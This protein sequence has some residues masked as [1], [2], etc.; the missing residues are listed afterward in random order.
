MQPKHIAIIMDGNHRWAK[1][2]ILPVKLG[3]KAGAS[4]IKELIKSALEFKIPYITIYAFSTENWSRP[5][6]EVEDLMKLLQ[7]YLEND[8]KDLIKYGVKI[9]SS[10]ELSKL[11]P[12]IEEKIELIKEKTKSNNNI[13][14]NVAFNYGAREEITNAVKN[15]AKDIKDNKINIENITEDLISHNLYNPQIPDPDLIIRTGGCNRLSNFLLWQSSYSELYF[16]DTLWPD[17]KREDLKNAIEN[18]KQ[19]KRNYGKR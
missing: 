10:G 16:T 18:F 15:I 12:K 11:N 3:H 7:N 19:R 2:R 8:V 6:E 17:F 14:L 5:E 13:T 4:S 1:K 9:I